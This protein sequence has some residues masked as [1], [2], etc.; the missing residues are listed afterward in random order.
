[1]SKTKPLSLEERIAAFHAEL[2][3]VVERHLDKVAA[4]CPGVPPGV[5]Q[6]CEVGAFA[7]SNYCLCKAVKFLSNKA[8]KEPAA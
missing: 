6:Q 8:A 2:K 3:A 5:L 4:E 7:R 1:M